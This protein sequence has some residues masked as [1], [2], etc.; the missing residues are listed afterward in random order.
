MTKHTWVDIPNSDVSYNVRGGLII[1]RLAREC[2]RCGYDT[3]QLA[4]FDSVPPE[5]CDATLVDRL[6]R[7]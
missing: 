1:H 3:S 7:S 4:R 2:S 6:M 5:D